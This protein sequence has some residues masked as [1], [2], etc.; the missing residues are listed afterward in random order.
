M[1]S[2]L[3]ELHYIKPAQQSQKLEEFFSTET[4]G[5]ALSSYN[6][7]KSTLSLSVSL[8]PAFA[9]SLSFSLKLQLFID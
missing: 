9:L 6:N 4:I 2:Y 7:T 3:L 5:W 1:M 8:P